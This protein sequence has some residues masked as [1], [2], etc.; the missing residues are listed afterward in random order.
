MRLPFCLISVVMVMVFAVAGCD[1]GTTTTASK[2][3]MKSRETLNKKTQRIY[4][5]GSEETKGSVVSSGKIT[6]YNPISGPGQAYVSQTGKISEMA[7]QQALEMYNVSNDHY[8]KTF[9]EFMD[10]VIKVGKPD[11]IMLPERPYY[12]EY[13][14]DV[15]NHKLV[16]LDFPERKKQMQKQQ[17]QDLGRR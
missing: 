8:P 2:P 10:E 3:K 11:G 7:V 14:Y 5:L 4:E 13:A 12:Q 9:Q 16:V 1:T 15:D 6:D 17:D